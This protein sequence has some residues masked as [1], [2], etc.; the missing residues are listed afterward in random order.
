MAGEEET[1]LMRNLEPRATSLSKVMQGI[2][3][4]HSYLAQFH[5]CLA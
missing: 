4:T 1:Y 3:N 2:A 5:Y